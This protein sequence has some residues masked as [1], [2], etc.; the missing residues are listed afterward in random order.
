L[1]APP[2][3]CP[4]PLTRPPPGPPKK[5]KPIAAPP[6][7]SVNCSSPRGRLPPPVRSNFRGE[8]KPPGPKEQNLKKVFPWGSV[9]PPPPPPPWEMGPSGPPPRCFP[10][11]EKRWGCEP[12]PPPPPHPR[13]QEPPPEGNRPIGGP[14]QSSR[15]PFFFTPPPNPRR[16]GGSPNWGKSPETT[17]PG[18]PGLET[19]PGPPWAGGCGPPRPPRPTPGRV[20]TLASAAKKNSPPPSDPVPPLAPDPGAR[21]VPPVVNPNPFFFCTARGGKRPPSDGLPGR[22]VRGVVWGGQWPH[23]GGQKRGHPPH[24]A[25]LGPFGP[26]HASENPGRSPAPEWPPPAVRAPPVF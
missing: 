3:P 6:R 4:A 19:A 20:L 22:R 2:A 15:G 25:N 10:S 17:P 12:P 21:P 13:A 24:R 7:Q 16:G 1:V 9:G 14:P 11:P 23:P 5:N 8:L 18:P 26:K